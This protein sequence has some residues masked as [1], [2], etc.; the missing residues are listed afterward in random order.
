MILALEKGRSGE[1]YILGNWNMEMRELLEILSR[2][3][4]IKAPHIK[5]PAPLVVFAGRIGSMV[6]SVTGKPVD[7]TYEIAKNSCEGTYYSA[8]KAVRELGLPQTP[9]ENALEEA[10]RW[11]RDNGKIRL[12]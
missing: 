6:A 12:K 7:L 1:C 9:I 2:I 4:G 11:L 5:V 3:V 8:A 10:Y